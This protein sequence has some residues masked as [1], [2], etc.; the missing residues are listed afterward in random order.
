MERHRI[1]AARAF[2]VL[3]TASQESNVKLIEVARRVVET[4]VDPRTP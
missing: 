1:T 4:G 2:D 3:A